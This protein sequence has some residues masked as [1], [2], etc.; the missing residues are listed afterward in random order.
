MASESESESES[1]LRLSLSLR[2]SGRNNV[3]DNHSTISGRHIIS[4]QRFCPSGNR[5]E[6]VL[7]LRIRTVCITYNSRC[8]SHVNV[9]FIG[10]PKVKTLLFESK[11]LV[12]DHS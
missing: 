10:I 1:S 4:L 6:N 3:D 2:L 9:M 5:T 12:V 8:N 7:H 11:K